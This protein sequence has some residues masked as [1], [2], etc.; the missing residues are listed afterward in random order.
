MTDA[1]KFDTLPNSLSSVQ[2]FVLKHCRVAAG[3][4]Q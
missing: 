3:T 1:E 2:N 4:S